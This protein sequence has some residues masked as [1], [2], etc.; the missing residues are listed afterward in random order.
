MPVK[1]GIQ[2]YCRGVWHAPFLDSGLRRNDDH[3]SRFI[4]DRTIT[5]AFQTGVFA[6]GNFRMT[7]EFSAEEQ[8]RLAPFF[9]NLDRSTF[10]LKLPQEV[11]G[12][13]F[14]RYSRS[15]KSLRRTFLDEF[16]GDPEL[17]LKDLL[18]GQAEPRRQHGTEKSASVLRARVGRLWRRFGG[19][20]GRRPSRLRK[21]FQR[22]RQASRRRAHRHRAAGE[23]DPLRALRSEGRG[24]QLSLLPRAKIMASRH[25][26]AYLEVMNLLFDTY[27]RQM[28]PM[29]ASLPSR[30]PSSNWK[31]AIRAAANP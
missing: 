18:G 8:K 6:R 28:E 23:I 26:D 15:T 5:L 31:C 11:A 24:G 19:A 17:G 22:R 4:L 27:S 30:C 29:L 1:T 16:L 13:L 7:A 25:R 20:I 21:Y 3:R 10:G 2:E 14:S 12:A 9:T